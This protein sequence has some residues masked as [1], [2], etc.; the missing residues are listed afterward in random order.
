[1]PEP[2]C[3]Q[4][5][6]LPK[7]VVDRIMS[8]RGERPISAQ[9]VNDLS[10]YWAAID[11]GM[12]K[13]ESMFTD[14]EAAAILEI[15]KDAIAEPSALSL[16]LNGGFAHQIYSGGYLDRMGKK[17]KCDI[18]LLIG[19]I[20]KLHPLALLALIDWSREYWRNPN[21]TIREAVSGFRKH[22]RPAKS[23]KEKTENVTR[24]AAF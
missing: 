16:L 12:Q 5:L 3:R 9:V 22:R 1:M 15:Q 4:S 10:M 14:S 6:Y 21:T 2:S 18:T 8:R 17:W 7:K 20:E 19:K 24:A 23:R 13:A 11:L